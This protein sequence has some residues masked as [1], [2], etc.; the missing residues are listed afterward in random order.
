MVSRALPS[1]LCTQMA[2]VSQKLTKIRAR[3]IV[4]WKFSNL[5]Q[6]RPSALYTH[7]ARRTRRLPGSPSPYKVGIRKHTT[8][9]PPPGLPSFAPS[10][11]PVPWLL[12]PSAA[13]L[14]RASALVA[15]PLVPL[16]VLVRCRSPTL[17]LP[18]CPLI[19][20]RLPL[21]PKITDAVAWICVVHGGSRQLGDESR[22]R[23]EVRT[24]GCRRASRQRDA[25]AS[26]QPGCAGGTR[27][28]HAGSQEHTN[29]CDA[30]MQYSPEA[31]ASAS[32][33]GTASLQ[34]SGK[35]PPSRPFR[36]Q[37]SGSSYQV[38]DI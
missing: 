37:P 23:D 17:P 35:M 29:T 21:L 34:A 30:A 20:R 19:H 28:G 11:P 18:S 4:K 36:L 22:R 6:H 10:P 16:L 12:L 3:L 9:D 1:F 2:T 26:E 7:T 8:L 5:S 27:R 14:L 25:M 32:T 15:P 33:I 24:C 13:P 38:S 31:S